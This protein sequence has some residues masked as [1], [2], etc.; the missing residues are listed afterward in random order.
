MI[1]GDLVAVAGLEVYNDVGLLRSVAVAPS[2][3]IQA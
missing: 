2:I 3:V 1:D